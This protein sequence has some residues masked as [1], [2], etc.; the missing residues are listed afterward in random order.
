MA[1]RIGSEGQVMF[2][3]GVAEMIE[4]D[5]GLDASDASLGINFEDVAHVP[6]EVQHDGDIAA[7]TSEGSAAAATEERS[8][9]LATGGDSRDDILRVIRKND[10]DGNLAVVG[11]VGGVKS[12]AAGIESDI[13]TDALP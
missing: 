8:P 6:G 2:L 5:S 12:A 7:L 11:S 10:P 4:N 3:R 1:G 13:A 9:E